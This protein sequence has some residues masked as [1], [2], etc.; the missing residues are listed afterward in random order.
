ME[1]IASIL[2][3][4]APLLLITLGA[5]ISEYAG[6][7]AMFVECMINLGAFLC[8]AFTVLFKNP[9]LGIILSTS[10]CVILVFILERLA[11][12]FNA[13]MFVC[14]LAMNLL[15]SALTSMLSAVIFKTRGVLTSD[16]FVFSS[17]SM[18]LW[19][20]VFCYAASLL[21]IF[22]IKFTYHGLNLRITGSSPEVLNA[23]GINVE[24][25][26]AF[27]WICAASF[28]AMSGAVYALRLSSFVPGMSSGRGWTALAAVFLGRRNP[29]FIVFAVSLF[30]IAE[31][32]SSH[33]Q[34]IP[35][36][37]SIPSSF[38][39]SLPYLL[40]LLLIV[41][42]PQKKEMPDK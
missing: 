40:S 28:S 14:S 5:L 10:S 17:S 25:Y 31:Y 38:L 3:I 4:A 22:F 1:A 35:I 36:F 8:F 9:I 39:I 41:I 24:R 19:T 6:R 27:S 18:K 2:F 21:T 11:H 20:S 23:N 37:A 26:R 15:F 42:V 12:K 29:L 34:N 16:S 13:N 7:L 32:C 33:I 30:A